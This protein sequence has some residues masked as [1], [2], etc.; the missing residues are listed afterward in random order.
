MQL[1]LKEDPR[2]WQK[3]VGVWVI[4]LLLAG[5]WFNYRH[6]LSMSSF[7][8]LTSFLAICCLAAGIRPQWFRT[9]YRLVTIGSFNVGQVMG[10]V[11]LMTFFLVVVT[12][13]GMVLRVLGKDLLDLRKNST[14]DTYWLPAKRPSD[15]ERMF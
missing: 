15:F 7:C 6:K 1:K 12:P 14:K 9:P 4:A 11:I 2:E 10:K 13:M 8:L 3:F 5:S